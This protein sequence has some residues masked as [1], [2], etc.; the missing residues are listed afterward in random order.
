MTLPARADVVVVG[1][2]NAALSSALV[3]A[4]AGAEVVVLEKAGPDEPGGNSWYTAGAFRVA[5]GGLE[6]VRPLLADPE[7]PRLDAT[8]LGPYPVEDFLDDLDRLTDGRCDR[9][10]ATVLAEESLDGL[11]WLSGH[12]IEFELMYHRQAYPLGDGRQRFWGGLAI[13]VV[14]GG[15][16]LVH[17][18]LRAASETGVTVIYDAPAARLLRSGGAITGVELADGSV[19]EAGAVVLACGGFQADPEMRV[20]HLGPAWRD[21]KLRGTAQNTGDGLRMALE[22]GAATAGDWGSCHAVAWDAASPPTGDRELTNRFT[23]QSYPLGI[24]VNLAG[25]RFVDEGADFR[26]YTYASLGAAIIRQPGGVAFQLFDGKTRP[27]LRTEEYEVPGILRFEADDPRSLAVAAGID[28]DGLMRTLAA[29]NAAAQPGPFEPTTK[30]GKATRGIDP[31]KSNWA[32]PLDEPPFVAVKVTCGITFTF[33]GLHVDVDGHV[34]GRDGEPLPGLY[35]AGE[36]AG[37][38]FAGNYP[39]GSGLTA[40][41]VFGRRAGATAALH[42]IDAHEGATT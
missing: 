20:E 17:E 25:E 2:G 27:L 23:K 37:G 8:E 30:D 31:P 15:K 40:G 6:E 9:E 4:E 21:A 29:F 10:L 32:L 13:G 41:T 28:P 16:A 42:A 35:A 34:L 7:D 12:G 19:C 3:A 18:Q 14:G 24:T 22:A 36:I 38:L 1:T 39:G 5:H 11:R 33:G 26:N